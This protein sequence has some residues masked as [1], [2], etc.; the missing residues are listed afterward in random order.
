MSGKCWI[1]LSEHERKNIKKIIELLKEHQNM[2]TGDIRQYFKTSG[3]MK[4]ALGILLLGRIVNVRQYHS[5]ARVYRLEK[6]YLKRLEKH[7]LLRE[8][9]R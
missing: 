3:S 7:F 8:R 9:K 2:T 1:Y 4:N 6:N 5:L